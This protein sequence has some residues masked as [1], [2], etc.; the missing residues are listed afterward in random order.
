MKEV[1]SKGSE[2]I[3]FDLWNGEEHLSGRGYDNLEESLSR[4]IRKYRKIAIISYD[5]YH[6]MVA[7]GLFK[8]IKENLNI[9][10]SSQIIEQVIFILYGKTPD[11]RH[12]VRILGFENFFP[13]IGLDQLL[14]EFYRILPTN[15]DI[16]ECKV[17]T[18]SLYSALELIPFPIHSTTSKTSFERWRIYLPN[19]IQMGIW[20]NSRAEASF[21]GARIEAYVITKKPVRLYY[22]DVNSLHG[23]AMAWHR[24]SIAPVHESMFGSD[25]NPLFFFPKDNETLYRDI[26]RGQEPKNDFSKKQRQKNYL[27][28]LT[29][30]LPEDTKRVCIPLMDLNGKPTEFLNGQGMFTGMDFVSLYQQKARIE[31]HSVIEFW[32]DDLFSSYVKMLYNGK[33]NSTGLLKSF[34]KLSMVGL[35]G[36]T[37][38]KRIEKRALKDEAE[39]EI[40]NG[41]VTAKELMEN[42]R[43]SQKPIRI[44]NQ[45]GTYAFPSYFLGNINKIFPHYVPCIGRDFRCYYHWPVP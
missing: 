12:T 40:E 43:I 45:H 38:Q 30:S 36:K 23:A 34:Y 4:L 2:N 20:V 41:Y 3:T 25:R 7:N 17:K 31:V 13:G 6:Q 42:A 24:Y 39:V 26:L 28:F 33:E 1:V 19:T 44:M 9:K 15:T 21:R 35:Y 16:E 5:P 10:V 27:I 37:A 22:Y 11:K 8:R 18:E 29:Y 14:K 32:N